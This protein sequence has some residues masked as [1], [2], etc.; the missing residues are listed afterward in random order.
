MAPEHPPELVIFDSRFEDG[1]LK[2]DLHYVEVPIGH[3][4]RVRWDSERESEDFQPVGGGVA[5]VFKT[6]DLQVLP[7][8]RDSIPDDLGDL[9]YRWSEGLNLGI[10]SMMFVLILPSG[11]TLAAAE[12]KPAR[13]KVLNDRLALYWI[14]KA[15]DMGRTQVVCTLSAFEGGASSKLVEL[16]R[17]CSGESPPPD[18]SIQIED[19][20]PSI[21]K[22]VFISYS[23]DSDAHREQ[24][25]RLSVRLRA[26][27]IETLLDQYENGSPKQGWPRW[28][29]DQLDAADSVLVVCTEA[30]Y[31]RFRGHEEPGKGKGVDWEGALITQEIYESRSR[32]LK[33]I[34]VFLSDVVEQWIPE[35]LRSGNYY[36]LTSNSAYDR[37]YDFLLG[38]AG[39]EPPPL[40][41]LKSRPRR[42]ATPLT[43]DESLPRAMG[44][45]QTAPP[46]YFLP[47]L[48]AR[49]QEENGELCTAE[50]EGEDGL[51][52]YCMDLWVK[53]APPNTQSVAFEILDVGFSDRAW[54][55]PRSEDAVQ[56]VRPFLTDEMNS[57]GDVEILVRGFET[58]GAWT[59]ETTLYEALNRYYSTRTKNRKVHRALK[60]IR[61]N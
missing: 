45:P 30:Y 26:D 34:P 49:F 17:F 9:R 59:L 42:K 33:F 10:P 6:D 58:N 4:L 53:D 5:S 46:S 50:G 1:K 22:R 52:S 27:G 25:L 15:D 23:H 41:E 2:G 38:Q 60:Q 28:M 51:E 3:R 13:A 54:N 8:S 14:L 18:G 31:R 40:G 32:T 37:L 24:V 12:P 11:Y 19:R 57:W 35:P 47:Q 7:I 44:E 55:I 48:V 20:S 61:E 43:F 16:N 29:L 39:V 36:A 21:S 56:P